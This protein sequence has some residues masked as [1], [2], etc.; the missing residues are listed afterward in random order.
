ML[1]VPTAYWKAIF[2]ILCNQASCEGFVYIMPDSH[3]YLCVHLRVCFSCCTVVKVPLSEPM[4]QVY[5]HGE[6]INRGS[7]GSKIL[8]LKFEI[9]FMF[10]QAFT[11]TGP[12]HDIIA[13]EHS[14]PVYGGTDWQLL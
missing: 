11:S 5:D 2:I 7:R 4:N 14:K 9:V 3:T 10:V 8:L 1:L 6:P 12:I 13:R